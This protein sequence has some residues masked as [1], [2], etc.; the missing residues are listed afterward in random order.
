MIY[1]YSLNKIRNTVNNITMVNVDIVDNSLGHLS[2]KTDEY[3]WIR[4]A[5]VDV[6]GNGHPDF[7]WVDFIHDPDTIPEVKMLYDLIKSPPAQ[8]NLSKLCPNWFMVMNK[9]TLFGKRTY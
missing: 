7:R 8:A 9:L 6:F 1:F 4:L 3:L 2:E 5:D